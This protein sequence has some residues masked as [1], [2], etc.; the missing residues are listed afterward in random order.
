LKPSLTVR[1]IAKDFSVVA[2][3]FDLSLRSQKQIFAYADA[4]SANLSIPKG[5]PGWA[6]HSLY[7]FLLAALLHHAGVDAF[8]EFV[9][10]RSDRLQMMQKLGMRGDVVYRSFG[11]ADEE[12]KKR[13]SILALFI[14]YTE[15]SNMTRRSLAK[16]LQK[17]NFEFPDSIAAQLVND[18]GARD[19]FVS[20]HNY[21]AL[22]RTAGGIRSDD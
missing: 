8:D 5:S 2:R 11:A 1:D 19:E 15:Y 10:G 14:K 13:L 16:S 18:Q 7:L 12:V 3:A 22:I 6:L 17:S 21:A 4:A 9:E 20:I